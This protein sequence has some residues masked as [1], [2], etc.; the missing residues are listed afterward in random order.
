MLHEKV[1]PK[2]W[3]E[4]VAQSDAVTVLKRLETNGGLGGKHYWINGKSGTGKTTLARIVASKV[5]DDWYTEEMDAS[6]LSMSKLR[7][8]EE[9]A[10][11]KPMS[12][13]S[14]CFIVNEAHGLR[15]NVIRKLLVMLE[16]VRFVVFIFTTSTE[17]QLRFEN[18]QIDSSPL[19][20]RCLLVSLSMRDL[21]KPF[22]VHVKAIA[23]RE[24]LDGKPVA[25]YERLLKDCGNNLR[26]AIEA[27]EAG[28]MLDKQTTPTAR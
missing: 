24:G 15:Q 16:R 2:T 3:S 25:A 7:E 21:C 11:Y 5:S 10:H 1:R 20:S 13:E 6:E 22:A 18:T 19:L 26:M 8:I 27:I 12:C 9:N 14:R 23:E 4:I 17:G 28:R